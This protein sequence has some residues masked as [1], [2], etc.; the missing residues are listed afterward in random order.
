MTPFLPL[1]I[2]KFDIIPYLNGSTGTPSNIVRVSSTGLLSVPKVSFFES[3]QLWDRNPLNELKR[4][5]VTIEYILPLLV[6]YMEWD[7]TILIY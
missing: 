5:V 6:L 7:N 2:V 4:P 1:H 3:G